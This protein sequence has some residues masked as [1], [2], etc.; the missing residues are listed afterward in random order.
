MAE[1][2][3][4]DLDLQEGNYS[5][6]QRKEKQDYKA[7]ISKTKNL[8]IQLSALPLDMLRYAK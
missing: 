4:R 3:D 7:V 1:E 5:L 2:G 8:Y 6:V